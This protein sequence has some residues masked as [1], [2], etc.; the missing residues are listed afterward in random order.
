MTAAL[1]AET[2]MTSGEP[3][4][5]S[6]V[7]LVD[8]QPI[9]A[10][11]LRR[12]VVKESDINL[13]YCRLG[14]DAVELAAALQ[15]TVILQDLVLSDADDGMDGLAVVRA[16]RAH[17]KT[18]TT[19]IIVLSTKEDP[20]IKSD[21]FAAGAN[22]YLVK[23]PDRAELIARIRYH[24]RAYLNQVQ[25]DEAFNALRES[26]Q[27]LLESNTMLTSLNQQLNHFVGMAAHDLRNPLGVVLGFLKFLTRDLFEQCTPQQKKALTIIQSSTEFMLRLVNDLLDVSR[28]EA[29]KLVL[30]RELVSLAWIVEANVMLNRLLAADKQITITV[31]TEEQMPLVSV[32]PHRVEQV[33]SNLLTNAIKY[34]HPGT[35]VD[36]SVAV[37]GGEAVLSVVDHG[38]GIPAHELDLLF[39]PFGVTSVRATGGEKST[40]LGLAIVK[41][42]VDA[43]GGRIWVESV[44]GQGATFSVAFPLSGE[45]EGGTLAPPDEVPASTATA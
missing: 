4:Y 13:H 3:E 20:Q 18:M 26:Q 10:E 35:T 42:V 43:H 19:P 30:N 12:M 27:R 28:I 24:S 9:V 15:P 38:Q 31:T 6:L 22:D 2:R 37:R 23:L 14:G 29:G 41:N 16:L 17:P 7:L 40:G 39:L 21:A 44:V 5:T 11:A 33:L 36:V 1:S 32:D 34:S 45:H 25:R 8:D